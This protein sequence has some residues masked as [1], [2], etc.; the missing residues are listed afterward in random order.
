MKVI[1]NNSK[2]VC[3][4][5][6]DGYYLSRSLSPRV[7][8]GV[9]ST[10]SLPLPMSCW[11]SR[12]WHGI[13][14][15][16]HFTT[17]TNTSEVAIS[18]AHGEVLLEI[19]L[20]PEEQVAFHAKYLVGF[21]HAI[22]LQTC[23]SFGVASLLANKPILQVASGPGNLIFSCSGV[24]EVIIGEVS[25]FSFSPA[26]MIAWSPNSEFI[27]SGVKK[28][29]DIYFNSIRIKMTEATPNTFIVLDSDDHKEGRSTIFSR[30]K[31]IF[32]P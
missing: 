29:L 25:E 32:I 6:S 8:D 22:K 16:D 2:I 3:S 30:L 12:L 14:F 23:I 9:N 13:Y 5:N 17:E 26:R 21:S 19:E 28:S 15:L 20:E 18:S 24:P 27:F 4:V 11:I 1:N 7:K 10:I 31:E